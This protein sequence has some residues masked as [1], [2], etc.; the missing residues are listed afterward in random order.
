VWTSRALCPDGGCIGVIGLDG[1]CKVCGRA[2]AAPSPATTDASG[3]AAASVTDEAGDA[4]GPAPRSAARCS[5]AACAGAIG[6]DRR[7]DVCGKVAA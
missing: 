7:C 4:V 2:A 3:N 5:D 1:R 6:P